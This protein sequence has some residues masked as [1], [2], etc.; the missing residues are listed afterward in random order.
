MENSLPPT[1]SS[2]RK[3]ASPESAVEAQ[4]ERFRT[5]FPIFAYSLLLLPERVYSCPMQTLRKPCRERWDDFLAD[6][7]D[8]LKFV[9]ASDCCVANVQGPLRLCERHRRKSPPKARQWLS[10]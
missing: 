7:G 3:K 5:G 6:G 8:V 4:L 2:P 1:L 9:P 10:S